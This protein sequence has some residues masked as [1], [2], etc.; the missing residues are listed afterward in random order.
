MHELPNSQP[1]KQ[2]LKVAE[3][4]ALLRDLLVTLSLQLND[5]LMEQAS[6]QRDEV[7]SEVERYLCQLQVPER[8]QGS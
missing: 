2:M 6:P 4:L 1:A 5:H 3:D 7:F 8:R